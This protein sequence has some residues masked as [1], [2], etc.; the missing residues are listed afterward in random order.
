MSFDG[1]VTRA[2]VHELNQTLVGGRITKIYQLSDAELL[3][4]IR[5]QGTNHK[6]LLS[7]HPA[8]PR[9]HLTDL[10]Q[11]NPKEPPMFCMLMRKHGEGAIIQSIEQVGLERVIH[12]NFRTRNDLGDEV[13][14]R[15]IV[16]IM[17]RHSN[18]I[19][20]D[21]ESGTIYDGIRRVSYAVS[22]YRQ[23]LPGVRYIEPPA[24]NKQNPLEMESTKFIGG[25]DYNQGQLE[26]QLMNRFVGIGP[27]HAKE[28]ISHA[29][30]G[31]RDQLW[32]SF[33]NFMQQ[34]QQHQYQ[35]TITQTKNKSYFSAFPLTHIN[36]ES[37][38]FVSMSE[39]LETYFQGKA[40]RDRV[41]QQTHDLIKKLKNEID[42]NEKKV[43]ILR[44]ELSN[45]SKADQ[46]RIKGEL[47][48]AYLHQV[49]RGDQQVSVVN[50]Y[51]PESPELIITLDPLLT[52][53]DNAQRYFKKYNKLKAAKK[54]NKE[55][56][57]KALH[58]IQYLESVLVQL[59]NSS[60]R[61]VEQIRD[62]LEEEGWLRPSSKK[63]KRRKAEKPL[64]TKLLSSDGTPIWVGRNNK[65]NDYLTH[66]L[67]S[68]Q[69]T[70]LHT[71]EIPGSHV[72][73]R[74]QAY[75]EQTLM[76]AAMLAAYFSKARE[77]SQVPVD[78][79]L[80]K[81]VKKPSGA[82]PGFVI[83]EQQKTVYVTPDESQIQLLLRSTDKS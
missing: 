47:L 67:A 64:P 16:E 58:E 14:R 41:R 73:I 43:E 28:I 2:I 57:D 56:I 49:K 8:Y 1:I 23:V 81:Q 3:F 21:P 61:E 31:D 39:C 11:D 5:A 68:S 24:Q 55:Q 4:H 82:R 66:Q 38:S 48:T 27:L 63:Q 33:H 40:E 75:S 7:A 71:K 10:L 25:F 22:Q 53:S 26:K 12:F 65:Q 34:I 30:L 37:R 29:G 42:K 45:A 62:E 13:S 35:P 74:S 60:L 54:W 50:Y 77:S 15:L 19:L 6:L 83:Y 9:I 36:G 51:E 79:T 20:V 59:E 17:G 80:I 69:D 76:E 44:K 32:L 72:V 46:Y 70:W 52:P 18:L 78:Y